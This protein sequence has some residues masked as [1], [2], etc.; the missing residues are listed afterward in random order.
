MKEMEDT[1]N[2]NFPLSPSVRK[3]KKKLTC[4]MYNKGLRG[5]LPIGKKLVKC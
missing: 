5:K 1:G 4:F 2:V 3:L